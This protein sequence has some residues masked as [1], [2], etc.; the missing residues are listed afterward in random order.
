MEQHSDHI[1][2]FFAHQDKAASCMQHINHNISL[3]V[4]RGKD[5]AADRAAMVVCRSLE[6]GLQ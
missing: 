1:I 4:L 5:S 2:L 3:F 6:K